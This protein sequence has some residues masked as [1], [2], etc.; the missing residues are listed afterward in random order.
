M[1]C[2]IDLRRLY[3][4]A[5]LED[6]SVCRIL[7]L[8]HEGER[9]G[10]IVDR[11]DTILSLPDNQRRPSPQLL[12][13]NGP[14]DMRRDSVEVLEVPGI[15]GKEDVLTLFD[16]ERFIGSLKEQLGGVVAA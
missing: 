3:G 10:L 5:P 16:K 15:D 9:F 13:V 7:V 1:V 8:E 4:M 6:R 12:R 11:V 2:V 14:Q